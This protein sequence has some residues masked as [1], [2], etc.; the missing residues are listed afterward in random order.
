MVRST[1]RYVL[2]Y[3]SRLHA[4]VVAQDVANAEQAAGNSATRLVECETRIP[5]LE[6][7]SSGLEAVRRVLSG[8]ESPRCA[9]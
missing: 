7:R 5:D 8:V 9:V 3:D 6:T 1:L 2:D 4:V